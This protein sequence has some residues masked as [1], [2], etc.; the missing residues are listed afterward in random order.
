M[1][2]TL[3]LHYP[4]LNTGGAEMST[5]RMIKALADRDWDITLVLTTGGGALEPLVDPRVRLVALRPRACGER[6]LHAGSLAARFRALP[7]LA[8]YVVMRAIGGLR[9]FSLLLRR[10]DA[11]AVLLHSTSPW[12]VTRMV[13]ANTRLHW[14]RTD[15]QGAD[16]DGHVA[17]RLRKALPRIDHFV[18]VSGTAL[19]SLLVALPEAA[20]RA[21]VVYNILDISAMRAA[22]A[23]GSDPFPPRRPGETRIVTIGRLW[24][25][26]KAIFR[27]AR[28]CRALKERGHCF[29]WFLFGDGPDR[30]RMTKLIAEL[31]LQDELQLLGEV[32][33]PFPAYRDA[34]LVA[35][36]SYREGL[37]GVINEAKIAGKAVIATEVSG[38]NEQLVHGRNGWIVTNEETAIVEGMDRLLSEPELLRRLGNDCYPAAILDDGAKVDRIEALFLRSPSLAGA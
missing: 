33:N 11:A 27:L 24:D 31:D 7:D 25:R 16:P 35:M 18:C 26:D 22:L 34:D 36:L 4:I 12:L 28:V 14:I 8:C 2:K 29:R 20:D 15:L 6:F 19:H 10:F 1:K 23:T 9:M 17:A 3:L 37:C 13:R 5:L 30:G 38:V 21:S 32:R